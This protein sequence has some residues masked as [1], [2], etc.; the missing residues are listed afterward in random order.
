MFTGESQLATASHRRGKTNMIWLNMAR[1]QE[2]LEFSKLIEEDMLKKKKLNNNN[3]NGKITLEEELEKRRQFVLISEKMTLL[4]DLQAQLDETIEEDNEVNENDEEVLQEEDKKKKKKN[5]E[6]DSDDDE[7]E[8]IEIANNN[9]EEGAEEEEEEENDSDYDDNEE[10]TEEEEEVMVDDDNFNNNN[11]NNKKRKLISN[12]KNKKNNK[13]SKIEDN[14]D[15]VTDIRERLNKREHGGGTKSKRVSRTT[16]SSQFIVRPN[17][18]YSMYL[19]G[20]AVKDLRPH[21]GFEAI[22]DTFLHKEKK[23]LLNKIQSSVIDSILKQPILQVRF[24]FFKNYLTLPIYTLFA[25]LGVTDMNEIISWITI[26]EDDIDK[27]RIITETIKPY[28][29]YTMGIDTVNKALEH[30]GSILMDS[31]VVKIND[32]RD[33]GTFFIR[34]RFYPHLIYNGKDLNT[35]PGGIDVKLKY[36][37]DWLLSYKRALFGR[38]ILAFVRVILGFDKPKAVRA[39]DTLI[40]STPGLNQE[41]TNHQAIIRVMKELTQKSKKMDNLE[42]FMIDEKGPSNLITKEKDKK[43]INELKNNAATAAA[44]NT[45]DNNNNNNNNNVSHNMY[46]LADILSLSGGISS[47]ISRIISKYPTPH[48][49]RQNKYDSAGPLYRMYWAYN[50]LQAVAPLGEVVSKS[51]K[52]AQKEEKEAKPEELGW[53]DPYEQILNDGGFVY[54]YTHIIIIIIMIIYN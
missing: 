48:A 34:Q 18:D 30:I 25:A 46:S 9:N 38:H 51:S 12:N 33:A 28:L 10:D 44:T 19:E 5:N 8:E 53:F 11:N 41:Y 50:E 42:Y 2:K 32:V 7:D 1:N 49:L 6:L 45:D 52:F 47:Y 26:S 13:K 39:L 29:I 21:I 4:N 14:D 3:N 54:I 16:K 37:Y 20:M 35:I 15:D 17:K 40:A 43:K 31:Y 24:K 36:K 27:R 22:H 23:A